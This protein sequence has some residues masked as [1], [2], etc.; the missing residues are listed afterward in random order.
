[1]Q[2]KI[3]VILNAYGG[4][5]GEQAK[6]A[7]VE[8]GMQT[9]GLDYQMELTQYAGH[10][11]ELARHAAADGWPIIV[12][13]GGDGTIHE[14]V[15]GL[16]QASEKEQRATLGIIPMGT[17]NDLADV[18]HLPR[19]VTAACQRIAAG[20]SCVI[21]VGT[22]N[23]QFF[24]NNSA[25]GLEPVVTINHE[26]MRRVKGNLRYLLAA[27]KGIIQ[28]KPWHM[29]LVWDDGAYEGSVTL[30]SVGNSNRTGGLFYMTPYAMLDDGLLD[31]V[32]ALGLTRW[33]LLKLLP[34]TFKGDHIHH[35]MVRYLRSK[36][37]SI[38]ASPCTPIQADGEVIDRTATEV[39]YSIIANKLR[40]IV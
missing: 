40:V 10:A 33:Q 32:Y 8:E 35:P 25:L 15:N 9:A 24:A 14:V 11:I 26:Q 17:A 36:S 6:T 5:L 1:V 4:S 31:I 22:V 7:L 38:T 37:V 20:N 12:A 30:V 13:A 23:G 3:K 19:D 2:G 34:K 28:A 21:D 29:R 18:M 16:M 39:N 27:L